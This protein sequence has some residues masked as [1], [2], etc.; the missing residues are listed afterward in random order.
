MVERSRGKGAALGGL[1]R[2]AE[3][4]AKD[5]LTSVPRYARSWPSWHGET[6][7]RGFRL[8]QCAPL[9]VS[10]P[11]SPTSTERRFD[12]AARTR[13]RANRSALTDSDAR[14]AG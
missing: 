12:A 13:T 1:V 4:G 11:Q 14:G 6:E 5:R 9:R 8:R 7:D 10:P 3:S 2:V